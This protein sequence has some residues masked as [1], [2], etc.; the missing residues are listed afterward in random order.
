ELAVIKYIHAKVHE[1]PCVE[2]GTSSSLR[3]TNMAGLS[4]LSRPEFQLATSAAVVFGVQRLVPTFDPTWYKSLKKPTWT[5]P[6][7][8]FPLVWIPLKAMQSLALML[9]WRGGT[10]TGSSAKH[11]ALAVAL[12]TFG[13]HLF[14]GNWWNVVF[15]GRRK[16]QPSLPWMYAFWGSVAASAAAFHPLDPRAATLMLPTLVWVTIA[17]KLNYDIV[18]LNRP[19]RSLQYIP[20]LMPGIIGTAPGLLPT[21]TYQHVQRHKTCVA[22][23][24]RSGLLTL[25]AA[26]L[27]SSMLMPRP[28]A[29]GEVKPI[30][31]TEALPPAEMYARYT[32]QEPADITRYI[33]DRA[34]PGDSQAVLQAIDEFATAFPMYRHVNMPGSSKSGTWLGPEKG[35][36]LE[37]AVALARP[38]LVVELGS[39]VEYGMQEHVCRATCRVGM[40]KHA[41]IGS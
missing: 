6:N 17:A 39:F 10:M 23:S 3:N 34:A 24:R 15:F 5:P 26:L 25:P 41:L 14:L 18:Q 7:Y 37:A 1:H 22:A 32:Y 38:Q 13:A 27:A 21:N 33:T 40:T 9:A 12:T 35:A 4:I 31:L 36:V 8:V 11:P 28:Y 2:H 16:L 20:A 30:E 19:N 29:R